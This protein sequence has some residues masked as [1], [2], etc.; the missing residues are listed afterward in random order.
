[1]SALA[2][3][4]HVLFPVTLNIHDMLCVP[5]CLHAGLHSELWEGETGSQ[6][7]QVLCGE[8]LSSEPIMTA[9]IHTE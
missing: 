8:H 9:Y 5:V 1:M 2:I 7:Q 3:C 4:G 6:A